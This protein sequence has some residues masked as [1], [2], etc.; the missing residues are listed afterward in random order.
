MATAI[1]SKAN[2]LRNLCKHIRLYSYV[3]TFGQC[4]STVASPSIIHALHLRTL[5]LIPPVLPFG[6]GIQSFVINQ[7]YL[8]ST[9]TTPTAVESEKPVPKSDAKSH[10]E[11]AEKSGDSNQGKSDGGKPV[12]GGPVSWLSFLLLVL[13]GAGIIWYYDREKKRH[14]EEINNASQAVKQGPSAGKAAIGGPFNLI[15]H[16]G[17]RVTD[18]DFLGNWTM[19]YFG[20]THCPDICPDELQKLAAAVDKTKEKGGIDVVPVFIS[21]D[22][23]RDTVE[24]VREYVKEFHP[25]LVGLTGSPDEIKKVARAYRVYYMKTAEEDSDYLVDHSIVMYL[26]S[27]KME[28]VKFFGKNNDVDS[29]ADGVIKEIKQH[30]K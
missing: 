22:P 13:T 25:K 3:G 4:R 6:L 19:I 11:G 26:M 15:N 21:V 20:F 7:R 17:K 28:F 12:R 23:E 30:K 5:P 2:H 1:A 10:S 24:Q 18:K 16:D 8:L 9:S 29:L 27:P 14:I